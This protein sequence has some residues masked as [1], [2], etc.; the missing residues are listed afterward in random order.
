MTYDFK[1]FSSQPATLIGKNFQ[2][3]CKGAC[4]NTKDTDSVLYIQEKCYIWK[5]L[6]IGQVLSMYYT[7]LSFGLMD[8]AL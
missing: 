2:T 6:E 7:V 3:Q 1:I 8:A 5:R 4:R